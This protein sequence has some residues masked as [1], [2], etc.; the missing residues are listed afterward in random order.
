MRGEI[1]IA[2]VFVPSLL[3]LGIAALLLAVPIRFL[4]DRAGFYRLV[5]SRP[6]VD[7]ALFVLVLGG[8]VLL[9]YRHG[10]LALGVLS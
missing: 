3:V 4:L 9:T 8:L 5:G 1:A 2:G 10:S 7:L 6:V